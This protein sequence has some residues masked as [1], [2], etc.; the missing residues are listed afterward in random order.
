GGSI[1][2]SPWVCS[3]PTRRSARSSCRT[4]R[5]VPR[6]ESSRRRPGRRARMEFGL[7]FLMQRDEAWSEQS[8]Y[9]SGLAQM[10]AAESLGYSSVW[11]AEHHFNDYGLCPAPQVL[12]SF[13]AA[14][15]VALRLGMGVSLLPLH[16]PIDLAEQLAV[17]DVVSGGRLD[18]GIG[19]GGT[20]QDYR[21]FQSDR[22]AARTRVGEGIALLGRCWSGR[23]CGS[24]TWPP[25]ATRRCGRPRRPSWATRSVSRGCAPTARAAAC[26]TPSTGRWCACVRFTSTSTAAWRCSARPT[27]CATGCR[28]IS[29][30][31]GIGGCCC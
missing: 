3:T 12:A 10:L 25:A 17:L 6:R 23:A 28:T 22:A 13:V 16:H 4:L 9:D 30:P 14:R 26:P 11:I 5:S 24:C 19:R 21:T 18:V 7:F 1:D 27:R 2:G 29:G 31:P 20:L 15:T 8:V